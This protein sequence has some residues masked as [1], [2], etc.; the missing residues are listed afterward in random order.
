M[1]GLPPLAP[2]PPPEVQSNIPAAEWELYMDAWVMLLKLRVE[3]PESQFKEHALNDASTITFLTSFFY[4]STYP[5]LLRSHT[6]PHARSLR[7]L[8]FL[9]T[10]RLLLDASTTPPELLDWRV[11]AGM[12]CCYP[13][14]S[15]LKRL[16]ADAWDQHEDAITSSLEKA[17]VQAIRELSSL[18]VGKPPAILMDLRLL[19]VLASALPGCGHVLMAGSDFLDT[20]FDAYQT[21]P[22]EDVRKVLV[23]NVY[24]GLCSFIKGPKPNLSSL[25]DQLYGMKAS[26]AVG[27]S[28]KKEPT[29][30]SDVICSTDFLARL[31]RHLNAD[32]NPQKRG[33]DLLASLRAYQAG[34][35]PLHRRYQKKPRKRAINKGKDR[36]TDEDEGLLPKAAEDLHIHKMSLITQV[37]DLFPDLGT[38]YIARLLDHYHDDPETIVAHLLDDSIAPELQSL[39]RSEPLPTPTTTHHHH[40]PFPPHSPTLTTPP[41]VQRKNIFDT[42][43]D[44][45]ELARSDDKTLRFGRANPTLTADALLSD[46][47]N[48]AAQK[49]AIMSALA[50]FDSDD[51]ERDDTYDVTDV[52]GTVDTTVA[53]E[54]E[55]TT[56]TTTTSRGGA[57]AAPEDNEL[58]IYRAYKSNP[59]LFGRDSATRRA[60]PRAALKRE[61]G[62][63]DE[64]I[65]GWAV[66][67]ARDPKRMKQLE[68]L[69]LGFA[70]GQGGAGGLN[71]P[72]L[73]STA[74]RKGAAAEDGDGDGERRGGGGGRGRGRGGRGR[75]GGGR[76]GGAGDSASAGQ[77]QNPAAARQRKEENKASR[78]NHNRRQQRAKKVARAGGMVG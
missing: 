7:K 36:A 61:T 66:M 69:A 52:G 19:T 73:A 70:P 63:T 40:D 39:D 11:L 27:A 74:Y 26:A 16:L 59:A 28:T 25:L 37:Q 23:A 41:P 38:G 50:T 22:R 44:L 18:N 68:D 57:G 67:L 35:Q 14:S 12:C 77:G 58:A 60:Q 20:V 31:D 48:H 43:V 49:A 75:G 1:P 6:A 5:G 53:A 32:V 24:V 55:T 51:D 78:A 56:S 2:V 76:G 34:T 62:L 15:A 17:K 46:R 72:V 3:L 9:L 13:S 21:H 45:A 8:C 33:Q 71:Q 54:D 4:Q 30:L 29:L 65:E 64:A 42:E 47:S 10:R